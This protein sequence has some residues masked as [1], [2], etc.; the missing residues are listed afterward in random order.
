MIK[1]FGVS[2]TYEPNKRSQ[3]WLKLKKDYLDGMGDTLDLVVC[4]AWLGKG[5]RTGTFGSYLVA[6][7]NEDT[8]DYETVAQLGTGFSDQLLSDLHTKFNETGLVRQHKPMEV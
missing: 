7:Y 1:L 5:K 3:K 2:S 6:V 8:E 4:G